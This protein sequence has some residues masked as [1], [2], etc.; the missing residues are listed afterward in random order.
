MQIFHNFLKFWD[1]VYGGGQ[2]IIFRTPC[3]I[4]KRGGG[5]GWW[6]VDQK[7]FIILSIKSKNDPPYDI[8][9]D[10]LYTIV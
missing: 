5:G 4:R 9:K 2:S 7:T 6:N 8:N 10:N 3:D 1:T